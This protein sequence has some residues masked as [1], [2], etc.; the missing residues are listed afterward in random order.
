[1]DTDQA[2]FGGLEP[3]TPQSQIRRLSLDI[4]QYEELLQRSLGPKARKMF[5]HLLARARA[6]LAVVEAAEIASRDWPGEASQPS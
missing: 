5:E 4:A 6:E 2:D 1:M 3:A